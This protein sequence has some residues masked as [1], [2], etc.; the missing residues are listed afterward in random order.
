MGDYLV[1]IKVLRIDIK[2]LKSIVEDFKYAHMFF[3]FILFRSELFI[4]VFGLDPCLFLNN[5]CS[6]L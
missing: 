3:V 4:C 2:A 1:Y 5:Y 6:C